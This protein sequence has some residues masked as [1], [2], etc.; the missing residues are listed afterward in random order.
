MKADQDYWNQY[1]VRPKPSPI[2]RYKNSTVVAAIFVFAFVGNLLQYYFF[3]YCFHFHIQFYLLMKNQSGGNKIDTVTVKK[4][5]RLKFILIFK[6]SG[7]PKVYITSFY[8]SNV[9]NCPE[10]YIFLV[11]SKKVTMT[12]LCN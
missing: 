12:Y 2:R 11:S 3:R 10:G 1:I 6:F 8:G 4:I 5:M 9:S 7:T